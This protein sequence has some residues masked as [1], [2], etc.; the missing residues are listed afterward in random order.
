MSSSSLLAKSMFSSGM[1]RVLPSS[2]SSLL[3]T[4]KR[5][6]ARRGNKRLRPRRTAPKK[7]V[8]DWFEVPTQPRMAQ[9]GERET[10]L[11]GEWRAKNPLTPVLDGKTTVKMLVTG[12]RHEVWAQ[13]ADWGNMEGW[14]SSVSSTVSQ[15]WTHESEM[16]EKTRVVAL[17]D[18]G[19]AHVTR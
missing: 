13:V 3:C 1:R 11:F 12:T 14:N 15:E 18:Y 6:F 9:L 19:D 8:G 5:F 4:P 16:Y 2:S 7:R 17:A 10:A